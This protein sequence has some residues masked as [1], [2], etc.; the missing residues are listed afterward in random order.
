MML[1]EQV[2]VKKLKERKS[3][4]PDGISNEMIS[5]LGNTA[6]KKLVEIFNL[7]W[8]KGEVPQ[9]WKDALMIPL[10]K[11]G[12]DKS[13][14]LS[15]RPIS[16]TSCVCKTMERT[17]NNRLQ[18]YLE[19]EM[20]IAPE[21]AGFR[22][23]RSTEDQTTHLTQVI[24]DAFQ[25]KKVVLASF[26]DLQ[27]AFD[28]VW[29]AGLRV[30]LQRNGIRGNMKKWIDSYLHNRKARVLVNGH[31]G[32]KRLLKEGVPQGGVLSPTLFILFIN[33]IIKELPRGI[34]AALYADDLVM[35]CSEQYATTATYMMQQTLDKLEKW[36][37][38]W[39]ISINKE[40]SSATLFTL[41]AQKPGKLTLGN[42][43]LPFEDEQTYLGVTYDKRLTWSPLPEES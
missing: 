31:T 4:G 25:R 19:K 39:S 29:K 36:T 9:I 43:R 33:D 3:P 37:N 27:K 21:Q 18:W 17:I 23:Y 38:M 16:L 5:H 34:Q 40:K 14:A 30:K 13:K 1:N 8:K 15:Y 10:H 32:R 26:I 42:H 7:S 41:T 28:E 2:A 22:Q 20:L 11:K 35:W 12:K 24:E 6:L